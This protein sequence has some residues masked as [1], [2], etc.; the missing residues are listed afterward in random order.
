[1]L[2]SKAIRARKQNAESAE[3]LTGL[4]CKQRLMKKGN[5]GCQ[6]SSTIAERARKK[7]IST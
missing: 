2:K 6:I 3:E 7:A 5:E 1:L 4:P